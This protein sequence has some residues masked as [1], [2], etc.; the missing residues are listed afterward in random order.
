MLDDKGFL[1][2]IGGYIDVFELSF[3]LSV[4]LK[5]IINFFISL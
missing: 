3:I 1:N 2:F 4:I 5:D